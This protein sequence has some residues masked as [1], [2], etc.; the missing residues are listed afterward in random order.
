MRVYHG[1][2]NL[3]KEFDY[4][5]IGKNVGSDEGKG[6]YFTDDF[7]IAKRF[8]GN[9]YVLECNIN[10]KKSLSETKKTI[11]KR[12][13]KKL[14]IEIQKEFDFLSY[15]GD[16]EWSGF[17]TILTVAVNSEYDYSEND[18]DIVSGLCNVIGFELV[19]P[20]VKK[21]LSYDG[22]VSKNNKYDKDTGIYIVFDNKDISIEKI[23]NI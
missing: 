13:L 19:L 16:V 21:I 22:I 12:D 6:F 18:V 1:T 4:N 11:P 20:L 2:K 8:S 15:Y 23:I 10:I 17:K 14:I 9:K 3:F 7:E 5:M